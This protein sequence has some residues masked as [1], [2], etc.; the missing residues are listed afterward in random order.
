MLS[1]WYIERRSGDMIKPIEVTDIEMGQ[2]HDDELV[3]KQ[4][5]LL[6]GALVKDFYPYKFSAGQ[7]LQRR[8]EVKT[9]KH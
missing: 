1:D 5:K 8:E 4:R 6:V 7:I 3:K 9:K 2:D